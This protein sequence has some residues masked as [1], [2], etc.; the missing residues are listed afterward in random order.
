MGPSSSKLQLLRL[1]S[2]KELKQ[3][4][5]DGRYSA[6]A[7][8]VKRVRVSMQSLRINLSPKIGVLA[9]ISAHQCFAFLH[10]AK[11]REVVAKGAEISVDHH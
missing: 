2:A 8:R 1:T 6:Q 11:D 4:A 5:S 3:S 10:A 7:V 9:I